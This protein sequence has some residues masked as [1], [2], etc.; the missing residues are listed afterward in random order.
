MSEKQEIF[1]TIKDF[2]GYQISNLKNVFSK[3]SNKNLVKIKG[4]YVDLQ[5]GHY[6][7]EN[8]K[9]E[10]FDIEYLMTNYYF[11]VCKPKPKYFIFYKL[12]NGHF[13]ILHSDTKLI[14]TVNKIPNGIN[15]YFMLNVKGIKADDE[16][17]LAYQILF[18]KC[19]DELYNNEIHKINY[20]FYQTNYGAVEMVFK[21][22]AKGK[23]EHHEVIDMI[24]QK[25][26]EATFKAGLYYCKSGTYKHAVGYDFSSAYPNILKSK[27]IEIPYKQGKEV[28]LKKLPKK[29]ELGYYHVSIL[30]DDEN[31]RKIF[32]FSPEDTYD[33]NSLEYALKHQEQ[34]NVKIKLIQDDE[35]NAYIYDSEFVDSGADIFSE[36]FEK[37]YAIKKLFPTNFLVKHLLSSIGGHLTRSNTK[38]YKLEEIEELGL[39]YSMDGETDYLIDDIVML[40]D[41]EY[42]VLVN[43][44]QPYKYNIRLKSFLLSYARNKVGNVCLEDI[45]NVVRINTDNVTFKKDPKLNIPTLKKESKTSGNIFFKN[46]N[47]YWHICPCGTHYKYD[48]KNDHIKICDLCV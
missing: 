42:Y 39:D 11:K 40:E 2:P 25:W 28:T 48:D 37:L 20:K 33:H 47:N 36:W 5:V 10:R 1:K 44:L 8:Y 24:E 14:E 35:P 9:K 41:Q 27:K 45:E 13:R 38:N 12:L 18:E 34:F 31:F 4:K 46:V 17:L 29:L 23:Y 22:F 19:C 26:I 16:G 6:Q 7:D 21:L 15:N 30:C 32:A 43:R 3:Q